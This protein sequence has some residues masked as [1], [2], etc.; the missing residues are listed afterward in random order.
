MSN[1]S[2]TTFAPQHAVATWEA[3][4]TT[5]NGEEM[6]DCSA[7]IYILNL[8]IMRATVAATRVTPS[9]SSAAQGST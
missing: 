1:Q 4:E 3:S 8:Q 6:L 5:P 7:M 2:P 9:A